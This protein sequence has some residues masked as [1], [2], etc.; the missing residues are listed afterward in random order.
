MKSASFVDQLLENVVLSKAKINM[1]VGEIRSE[2]GT[3][4]PGEQLMHKPK[5]SNLLVVLGNLVFNFCINLQVN[6][7][8][9][10]LGECKIVFLRLIKEC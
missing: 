8:H 7:V 2:T 1:S 6:C 4:L 5:V 10:L 3:I 9:M